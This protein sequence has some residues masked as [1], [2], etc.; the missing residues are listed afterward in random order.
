MYKKRSKKPVVRDNEVLAPLDERLSPQERT[1]AAIGLSEL[2]MRIATQ[3][4]CLFTID[5]RIIWVATWHFL[6]QEY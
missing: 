2:I 3:L 1:E 5:L 4:K 6:M